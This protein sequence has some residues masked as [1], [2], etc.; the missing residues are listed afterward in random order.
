MVGETNKTTPK[1]YVAPS[2]W[3]EKTIHSDKERNNQN[4][5]MWPNKRGRWNRSGPVSQLKR[6][7]RHNQY[8]LIVFVFNV[9]TTEIAG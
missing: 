7:H 4:E 3:T 1:K 9:H 5:K 2:W 6:P 8:V